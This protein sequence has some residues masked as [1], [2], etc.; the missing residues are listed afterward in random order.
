MA[1]LQLNDTTGSIEVVVFPKAYNVFQDSCK[2]NSVCLFKGKVTE[3]EGDYSIIM[4][5][6][7]NLDMRAANVE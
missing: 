1:F 5:K 7:V 6:A 4:D 3:R 2:Q